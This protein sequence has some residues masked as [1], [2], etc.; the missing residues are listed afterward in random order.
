MNRFARQTR[1]T[2]LGR[3]SAIRAIWRL[4]LMM[5]FVVLI[6][7]ETV[8]GDF[9]AFDHGTIA[10]T[11]RS[12]D[13]ITSQ[14]Q[15]FAGDFSPT[16]LPPLSDFH[17]GAREAWVYDAKHPVPTQS[18]WVQWGREFYAGGITPRGRNWFGSTN[19]AHPQFYVYGDTRTGIIG[20]RNAAGRTD[21]LST[22]MNLDMDL[23]LTDTERF[24]GFIGPLNRGGEISRIDFRDGR[25]DLNNVFDPNFVTAFF[26][27]DLG[28]MWGG[29]HNKPSPAE[30]PIAIGLVPLLFQNGIWLEDA[31]TG[32][33]I[34]FPARHSR[35]LNW[36]NFDLTL[37]AAIDHINSNAF[38][39]DDHRGQF[40]GAAAFIEA[41][42]GY[43]ESGYAF[44]RDRHQAHLNYHNVTASFTRRYFDRVSNSL[45][46]ILNLGQTG[47][48]AD[49]TADGGLLLCE[50]SWI[51]ASPLTFVPY[52]NAFYGWGRPQSVARAGG[53]GGILRN[54][55]INFDTDGLNGFATLDATGFDTAG[56]SLGV[57]LLGQRLDRQ[58]LLEVAYLTR[59]G[60][61]NPFVAGDQFAIGGRYQFPITHSRLLRF[62]VMHG[63]RN[64]LQNVYGTRMEYRWKF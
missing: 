7:S 40:F 35:L 38:G 32:A 5:C 15:S 62:D 52:A 55:G 44:V 37:F 14:L 6:C 4:N 30:I 26:E 9:G 39:V 57:D 23:R 51:T 60:D 19:L 45:R 10:T 49:R 2:Q 34:G 61:Q 20:G 13:W 59:H 56:G 53:S 50:N 54:T 48:E 42:G 8:G 58:L 27:G 24:H 12:P 28:A 64:G 3:I 31:V 22:L 11:N 43:I 47:P 41:Y 18:P 1:C 63:W 25:F 17:D 33:A 21:N 29:F 36:S 46:V 16:P